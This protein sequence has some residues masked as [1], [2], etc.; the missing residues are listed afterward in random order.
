MSNLVILTGS[1][2]SGK[3]TVTKLLAKEL[4]DGVHIESDIFYSFFSHPIAPHLPAANHQ[5]EAAI[6]ASIQAALAFSTR[7]YSVVLEEIF[8]P[9]FLPLI[10]SEM[11][12]NQIDTRYIVLQTTLEE[13]CERVRLRG[14]ASN[15]HIVKAMHPQFA[16]LGE[17][18]N[19]AVTTTG[20]TPTEVASRLHRLLYEVNYRINLA[21]GE[22]GRVV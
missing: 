1:L 12:S 11:T 5:N 18:A 2:G 16:D 9:W 22:R 21:G 6:A 20:A 4:P 19:H 7:G 17:F 15:E 8:G 13:A 10:S 14:D 3:T